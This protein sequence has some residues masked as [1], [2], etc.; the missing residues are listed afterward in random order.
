MIVL[1]LQLLSIANLHIIFW[2]HSITD[3]LYALIAQA[4]DLI[5]ENKELALPENQLLIANSLVTKTIDPF[6]L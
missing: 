2:L 1:L 4:D 5:T 6:Y 3:Y